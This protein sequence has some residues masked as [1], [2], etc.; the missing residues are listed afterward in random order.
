MIH[1]P[2]GDLLRAARAQTTSCLG[3]LENYAPA[4]SLE[5]GGLPR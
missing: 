5:A 3:H 1:V 2:T 4:V